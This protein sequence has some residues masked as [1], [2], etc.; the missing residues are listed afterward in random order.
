MVKETLI[1][2]VVNSF[3]NA[4]NNFQPEKPIMRLTSSSHNIQTWRV[5]K[6]GKIDK[7]STNNHN[8]QMLKNGHAKKL[9]EELEDYEFPIGVP[10]TAKNG[11][12]CCDGKS[13]GNDDWWHKASCD[14]QLKRNGS[15]KNGDS[16]YRKPEK[17][18]KNLALKADVE[19]RRSFRRKHRSSAKTS[20]SSTK[21][22]KPA[23]VEWAID[24]STKV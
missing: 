18:D 23:L 24:A 2:N 20:K 15:L 4:T 5:V 17:M 8:G 21:V 14:K 16:A 7:A 1:E 13:N 11:D 3:P 22:E 9:I 6:S 10:K 19:S 12:D